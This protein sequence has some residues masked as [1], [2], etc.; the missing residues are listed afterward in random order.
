MSPLSLQSQWAS[1]QPQPSAIAVDPRGFK[2]AIQSLSQFLIAYQIPATLWLKLPKDDAWWTDIWQYGQQAPGCTIY[3]LGDQIGS[4]PDH[5]A[6]SLRSIPLGQSPELKRE[7]LCLAVS[8]NF[9]GALFAVRTPGLTASDGTSTSDKR[10][11]KLYCSTSGR[12][13]AALSN[14]IKQLIEGSLSTETSCSETAGEGKPVPLESQR[15]EPS[16]VDSNLDDLAKAA[17][18]KQSIFKQSMTAQAIL[19]QWERCFPNELLRGESLPLTEAFWGWQ[20][21]AQI[22]LKSQLAASKNTLVSAADAA[23]K[24]LSPD[25]LAQARQELQSPLTTIKTALTLLGSPTLK[26][27]Q[28]QRYLEMIATQCDRQTSLINSIIDLLQIQTTPSTPPK[29]LQLADIIPGIVSTYQP[30]A[31]ERGIMLA[32]TV[33]P[34][35]A[36]VLGAEAE[37]KQIMIYLINNGMQVTPKGGRVWVAA[38]PHNANFV[39]LTIEDSGESIT[40][41]DIDHMFSA[42]YRPPTHNSEAGNGLGLTLV[43]QLVN[44]MNG[45]I[46]VESAPSKGTIF[47][48]LLP[49]HHLVSPSDSNAIS[50]PN[51][52][53]R[54]SMK[55][56]S[57][58]PFASV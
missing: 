4:P 56:N 2:S 8:S 57:T 31:E 1:L 14:G 19:N 16:G 42:F 30:I 43:Q 23:L 17:V 58:Q 28:R 26:L 22:E 34:T 39:A 54:S 52:L 24:S 21:Q 48:I 41:A 3:T 12:T 53:L 50:P 55:A 5:L 32:Y 47:N 27:T 7:Y 51:R 38:A 45:R 46:F 9:V 40:K 29:A 10:T 36:A 18:F 25:F 35:L 6:A 11:L 37:L 15:P 20:L 33:P 44:R 13:V 49:V